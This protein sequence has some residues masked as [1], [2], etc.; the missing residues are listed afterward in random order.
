MKHIIERRFHPERGSPPPR[1]VFENVAV[2]AGFPTLRL[3]FFKPARETQGTVRDGSKL[4][5]A[6]AAYP[7]RSLKFT[8]APG[9]QGWKRGV[10]EGSCELA[11]RSPG[12]F[13]EMQVLNPDRGVV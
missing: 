2:E 8:I 4:S 1:G 5:S 13:G 11:R 3:S 7:A 9:T 12:E 6:C 10:D